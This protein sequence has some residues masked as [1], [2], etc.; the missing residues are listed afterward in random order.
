MHHAERAVAGVGP[1]DHDAQAE[2]VDD[3]GQRRGLAQHLAVDAVQ[4]FLARAD[5][6]LQ[7]RLHQRDAHGLGDLVEE[8][9]LVAARLLQRAVEHLVAMRKRRLEAEILELELHVVEPEPPGDRR[10]DVERLARDRAAPRRRHGVERAHVVRAVRELHEDHAQVAHHRQHHLAEGF[11]LRLGARLEL[12]LVE[13]GDAVD[14]L[15]HRRAEFRRQLLLGDRRVFD[16]VVQDRRDDRVGIQVQI[17]EDLRGRE[18]VRDVRLAGE[19]L[20]AL[21]RLRAEFRGRADALDLLGRQ[22]GFDAVDQ[23]AQAR[24]SPGT[25]QKLKERRRVIHGARAP[26]GKGQADDLFLYVTIALQAELRRTEQGLVVG[27]GQRG[28]RRR[29]IRLTQHLRRDVAFGD[30]AQGDHGGLVVLPGNGGLGAIGEAARALRR[31]AARA[32]R[33]FRR[34]GGNLRR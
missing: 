22:I 9:L 15:G 20:L 14:D 28:F 16:D 5:V 13:L 1:I 30:L 6:G 26:L 24:Q 19:P 4:M 10:V 2:H 23:L 32:G 21:V 17:R 31:P 29:R 27:V 7:I 25:G 11:G 12:D 8:L 18:R 33:C 34:S 3:L